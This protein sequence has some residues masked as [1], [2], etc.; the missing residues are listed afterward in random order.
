MQ[1]RN[2]DDVLL[3]EHIEHPKGKPSQK[4]SAKF[5]A[6]ETERHWVGFNATKRRVYFS[7]EPR[8]EALMLLFVPQ[9]GGR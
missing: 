6:H 9:L 4:C 8:A 2:D 3:S 7:E 1:H 5:S